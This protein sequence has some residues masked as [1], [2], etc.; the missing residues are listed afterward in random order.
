MH[1]QAA[2]DVRVVEGAGEY[3]IEASFCCQRAKEHALR[4]L[5]SKAD[6]N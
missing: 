6:S 3:R 4:A 2:T 5:P 1:G